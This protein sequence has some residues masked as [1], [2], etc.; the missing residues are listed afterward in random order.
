MQKNYK[1]IKL[2]AVILGLITANLNAQCVTPPPPTLV[3]ASPNNIC[4]TNGG[5]TN[6]N[7]TT[8]G[9]FINWYTVPSGG[10]PLGFSNSWANFSVN[11]VSTTTYYAEATA[12]GGTVITTF[13]YTGGTQTFVVPAGINTV[14]I[15]AWGA[16]GN[17]NAM[18]VVGG[19]GGYAKGVMTVTPGSTLYIEVG[20]GGT[21]SALGGYNGGGAAGLSTCLTAI[22]G[23]GGGASDVRV[24]GTGLANRIIVGAGGGGAAGDRISACGRG[25]GGGGGAGYY[26][27]G[28]GAAWPSTSIVLPL[29]GNQLTGGLGGTSTYNTA[30]GNNGSAGALGIGG[31]GGAEI[32]SNQGGAQTAITGGVGGGTVGAIGAYA[33][34]FTGQSG[35]GG[36]SFLGSLTSATTTAGLN[37]GNGQIILTFQASC[38]NVTRVP[39]TFTV[40][41]TPT[42]SANNGTIC[43]GNSFSIVP[44]GAN[45]YTIQGG[46]SNVSPT[47]TSNYTVIG[48]SAQGCV[49]ANTATS[50]VNVNTTPTVSVNSGSI[51]SGN[52][53]TL[54]PSGALTYTIAGG[55]AVVSPLTNTVYNVIGM[56]AQG[57]ISTN[58]AVS[59]VTVFAIPTIS[60]NSGSICSGNSFTLVPSGASTFTIAGGNAVVS[61]L[62]NTVY[63]VTGT[64]AQGCVSSNTAVSTVTV[65]ATPTIS[66]N[67]GSIC[68]GRSFTIVSSGAA[69]YTIAGGN[70]IVSPLTNTVYN[71]TGTSAQ[72]CVSSNTAVS[73]VTVIASPIV[74]VNSGSICSG[75]SFTMSPSGASTYTFLNGSAIVSPLTNTVYNVIGTGTNGCVSSNTAVSTLTVN[76]TPTIVVNSGSIC[77]GNSFTMSPSGANTYTF[78]NGSAIVSPLTNTVYNVTGTSSLGCV[79]S[80]TAVSSLTVNATP[81]VSVNS[82][83]I[84]SGKSFTIISSGAATYTITGGNTVVSPLTNTVYTVTGTSSLG[85]VSSNTATSSVTVNALPTITANSGSICSG[86]SFV[87]LPG[88]GTTYTVTG[89]NFTVSPVTNTTYSVNG[90]NAQGCTN[91][92]ISTVTVN[93]TPIILVNSGTICAGKSFTIT[94]SGAATYTISG[95]N[96]VVN[97]VTTTSYSVTGT[98][99]LGC[100]G[101]AAINTVVVNPL[102]LVNVS[103]SNATIC[104]GETATL[105]AGGATAYVWNTS[106]N[107]ASISVNPTITTAYTVTG[108]GVNGCTKSTT[109]S[110]DVNLCTGV[111]QLSTLNSQ[112]FIFPN[113][114]NGEF[115]IMSTS[116]IKLTITNELGQVIKTL[117]V[118]ENSAEKVSISELANGIYFVIGQSD[119]QVVK[120]KIVVSK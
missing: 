60:V 94:P 73:S 66:V 112:L 51:C 69:T 115:T 45:T 72:G 76:A 62:T 40:N 49:S 92:A 42:V 64:S 50:S 101:T 77:T 4:S 84:C 106:S 26:G 18:N 55:S 54:V 46:S 53:F 65:N 24:G 7:A 25:T 29:G 78:S 30:P 39:L 97:P 47:S 28:G 99:A 110:Q 89:G 37:T 86:N 5:T 109:V 104:V 111:T 103:S 13:S 31:A 32:G 85:C 1:L 59:T 71:V 48:T 22:G 8:T 90:T 105:T 87:I 96:A 19:L 41:P 120:Q 68:S 107:T 44:I 43:S 38:S 79:S 83:S 61:P 102:P 35:A 82:G 67:S 57:C 11:A 3:S 117:S 6:L 75:N 88:G 20:G 9:A 36:S 63:N 80:N 56:S 58:T 95:G 16:Q 81:I 33:G 118:T 14:Q 108:T 15:E 114:N 52:S 93:T 70:A 17:S 23:G 119:N 10:S 2:F 116:N 21:V 74:A 113:P 27:G 91:L 100:A 98:S 12:L 34:N